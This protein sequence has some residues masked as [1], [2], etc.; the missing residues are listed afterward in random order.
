MSKEH[1]I[2]NQKI[3]EAG[4]SL[5]DEDGVLKSASDF[6]GEKYEPQGIVLLSKEMKHTL[7]IIEAKKQS[8]FQGK[9]FTV[10]A[11]TPGGA[12]IILWKNGNVTDHAMIDARDVESYS[13]VKSVDGILVPIH[14]VHLE[15]ELY[16]Y[17]AKLNSYH[18]QEIAELLSSRRFEGDELYKALV[19]K[20]K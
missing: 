10:C 17:R 14:M 6:I 5:F 19:S 2:I 20:Y 3:Q 9:V 8:H 4:K 13:P 12:Y 1:S 15:E 18:N 11:M 16:L 7:L